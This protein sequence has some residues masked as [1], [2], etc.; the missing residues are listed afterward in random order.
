MKKTRTRIGSILLA[1]ALVLTLLPVSALAVTK[2]VTDESTLRTAVAQSGDIQLGEDISLTEGLAI[3]DGVSVTI[4]LNGKTLSNT[5]ASPLITV[6]GRASL[7]IQD[8]GSSG[9]IVSEGT[10]V[11]VEAKGT[12][13]VQG[14][15]LETTGSYSYALFLSNSKENNTITGGTLQAV[16]PVISVGG[17]NGSELTIGEEESNNEEITIKSTGAATCGMTIT[18][19]SD[20]TI[21]SGTFTSENTSTTYSL[22]NASAFSA[23]PTIT[24]TGGSF[25]SKCTGENAIILNDAASYFRV[26]G[27]TFSTL[28]PGTSIAAG[29]ALVSA[30][31]NGGYI[32]QPSSEVLVQLTYD[33][34]A[35]PVNYTSA[36]AALNAAKDKTNAQVTVVA[37]V[38]TEQA[39]TVPAGVT[40]TVNSD[41]ELSCGAI[42]VSKGAKL[43][44]NGT[45]TAKNS[46]TNNG[47]VSNEGT[48]TAGSIS[49]VSGTWTNQSAV[50]LTG[51]SSVVSKVDLSNFKGGSL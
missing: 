11:R 31:P 29:H 44:N 23:S 13:A 30:G 3:P 24:I 33:G 5:T 51:N 47:T 14:G 2:I 49:A 7:T 27:G 40:L 20:V 10:V 42:T 25:S 19:D 41:K 43:E 48:L 22:F 18:N 38:A 4:D 16:G 26:S 37:D 34:E 21:H 35:G 15:T 6:S 8:T 36:E 17:L 1:L 50:T 12:I 9:K 28:V 45:I 39:L 46:V 32:V